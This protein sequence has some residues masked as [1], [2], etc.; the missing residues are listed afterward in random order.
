MRNEVICYTDGSAVANTKSKSCGLGGYGVYIKTK[1]EEFY[2][3]GGFSNTKTGRMELRAMIVALQKITDKQ[4]KVTIYSDSEYAVKCIS[5]GRLW[6]WEL[7]HWNGLKNVDL[8]KQLLD[9]IRNFEIRPRAIH[10]KGHQN[11]LTNEHIFGNN[12]A[13]ILASY[14][15]QKIFIPDVL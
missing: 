6:R 4:S 8:L 9:E 1:E 7:L 14:N 10:I 2:F 13:D 5:E 15:N 11:D 12:V 3:N